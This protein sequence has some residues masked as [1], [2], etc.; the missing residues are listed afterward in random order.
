MYEKKI[1]PQQSVRAHLEERERDRGK[2]VGKKSIR[3]SSN[4]Y[5]IHPMHIKLI[6]RIQKNKDATPV[7]YLNQ[8]D[9]ANEHRKLPIALHLDPTGCLTDRKEN[10]GKFREGAGIEVAHAYRV[11]DER[12][13]IN[14]ETKPGQTRKE[15]KSAR[16]RITGAW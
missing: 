14:G 7:R 16:C 1:N 3:N 13:R 8:L 10:T 11:Y 2:S 12:R 4:V 6:P 5:R 9:N 15:P